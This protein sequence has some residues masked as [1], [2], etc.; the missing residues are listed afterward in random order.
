MN[1]HANFKV[2]MEIQGTVKTI[3]QEK[4]GRLP[5]LKTYYTAIVIKSMLLAQ[6]KYKDQWNK[7]ESLEINPYI[8]DQLIFNKDTK[9]NGEK[10]LTINGS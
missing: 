2:L 5:N 7:I 10:A 8:H 6:D 1:E 3:L 4:D 9:T